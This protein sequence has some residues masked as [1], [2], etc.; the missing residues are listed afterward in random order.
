MLWHLSLFKQGPQVSLPKA[1]MLSLFD[2]SKFLYYH[3]YPFVYVY[4]KERQRD[5]VTVDGERKWI[6]PA[7]VYV[8]SLVW[9]AGVKLG[10]SGLHSLCGNKHHYPLSHL[11][12][13]LLAFLEDSVATTIWKTFFFSIFIAKI[14]YFHLPYDFTLVFNWSSKL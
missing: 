9:V 13:N 7:T 2:F 12:S 8:W 4:M 5:R 14:R 3:Y 10:S 1:R 6:A 11:T